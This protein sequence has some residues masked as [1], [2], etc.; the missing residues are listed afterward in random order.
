MATEA[1]SL[2]RLRD[3]LNRRWGGRDT[4]S[5]GWIGDSAH[6]GTTSDHN[7]DHRGIVHARDTDKDG[8]HMPTWVAS[9]ILHPSTSYAIFNRRIYSRVRAFIPVSYGGTNPHTGHGHESILH[10][11]AAE[12]STAKWEMIETTPSWGLVRLGAQA[13]YA[14][15]VQAYLNGHG[16]NLAIDGDFGVK[17]DAAV[18]AFQRRWGL[19]VDGVVGPQT[20]AAFRTK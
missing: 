13:T 8:I 6:Q 4:S 7:P 9:C 12:N 2:R 17:T 20:T 14:R 1:P 10:T 19:S 11:W 18:R 15:Q 5:D 3:A 16:S